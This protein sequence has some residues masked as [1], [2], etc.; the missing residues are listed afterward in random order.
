MV[1]GAAAY[2]VP[3]AY[4]GCLFNQLTDLE[5]NDDLDLTSPI[6]MSM[7]IVGAVASI[8][9]TVA[10]TCYTKKKLKRLLED[11]E[12]I[13]EEAKVRG[14][15]ATMLVTRTAQAWTSV[16]DALPY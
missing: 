12:R 9:A 6:G 14:L 13:S 15:T 5:D 7:A 8:G 11:E 10:L 2:A 16:Q 4:V 3:L 1:L